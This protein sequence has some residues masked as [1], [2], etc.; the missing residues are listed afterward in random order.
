MAPIRECL[1]HSLQQ[2]EN[3][4]ARES[5]R[6]IV[7]RFMASLLQFGK[8]SGDPNQFGLE[9]LTVQPRGEFRGHTVIRKLLSHLLHFAMDERPRQT[10]SERRSVVAGE[11]AFRRFVYQQVKESVVGRGRS[12]AQACLQRA[13]RLLD[14]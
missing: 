5:T 11:H 13:F 7:V 1:F 6:D 14:G 3:F 4:P 12:S 8:C 10:V 9:S 2:I